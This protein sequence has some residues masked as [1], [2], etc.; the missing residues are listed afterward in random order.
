MNAKSSMKQRIKIV[1]KKLKGE[2]PYV[3]NDDAKG[4]KKQE[5]KKALKK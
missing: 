2:K 3:V 1:N 4:E 5:Q